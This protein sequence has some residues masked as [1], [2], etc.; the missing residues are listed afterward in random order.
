MKTRA[1]RSPLPRPQN[2][3]RTAE[4]RKEARARRRKEP[5]FAGYA[6][7]E[8]LG[9]REGDPL[10]HLEGMRLSYI[11]AI[12]DCARR[13]PIVSERAAILL[14]LLKFTSLGRIRVDVSAQL[15]KLTPEADLRS[16]TDEQ[17]AS[18]MR[19]EQPT[20]P[21]PAEDVKTE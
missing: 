19:G 15:G 2:P 20:L 7:R 14:K 1:S 12:E 11:E 10:A 3:I 6:G 17:L 5:G 16:L 9:P 13:V 18:I 4:D 8:I 21:A